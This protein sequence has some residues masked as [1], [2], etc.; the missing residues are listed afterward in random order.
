MES[1]NPL[2]CD[3]AADTM[4]AVGS[5]LSLLATVVAER[6]LETLDGRPAEGVFYVLQTCIDALD[7]AGRQRV[8]DVMESKNEQ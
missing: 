7:A 8:V 5:V 1:N 2:V 6:P 3:T 4:N